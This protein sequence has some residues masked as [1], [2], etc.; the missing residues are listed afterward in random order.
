MNS[1]RVVAYPLDGSRRGPSMGRPG[2]SNVLCRETEEALPI[3]RS[4]G[5]YPLPGHGYCI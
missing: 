4:A 5:R 1:Q 2:Q 3:R